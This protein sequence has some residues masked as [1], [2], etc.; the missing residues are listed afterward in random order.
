MP[1]KPCFDGVR[2][3]LF[4]YIWAFTGL[5]NVS[6]VTHIYIYICT[7][8]IYMFSTGT[9]QHLVVHEAELIKELKLHKSLD[10]GTPSY[11]S[12]AVEPMLG[13][14]II[15]ANGQHWS[16]QKKLIAPEFFLHKVKGIAGLMEE[17]TMAMISTWERRLGESSRL[18]G[19]AA[20]AEFMV[21]QDLRGLSADII[22]RY[23]FGSSFSQGKNIFAKLANLQEA[24]SHQSLVFGL[25]NF[26]CKSIIVYKLIDKTDPEKHYNADFFPRRAIERYGDSELHQDKRKIERFIVD[27]CKNIYFAGYETTAL[28]ASW[29]LMLL[30]LHP[31]WQQRVQA[32]IIET[33]SLDN[34]DKLNQLKT[35]SMV[36]QESLRLYAPPVMLVREAFEDIKLGDFQLPKGVHVWSF[37]PELHR[38][39]DNWGPDVGEFKPERFA[40]GISEA[41]KYPQAYVPFGYGTRMCIGQTFAMLELK[42]VLSLLLSRF[43]FSMSPNYRHSP[44]YKMFVMP[45]YGMRLI[46]KGV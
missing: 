43:S 18:G 25:P 41:C 30:A 28:S 8:K 40:G 6:I 2:V 4:A 3:Y 15:K 29:T 22:S 33:G 14:G 21:D 10:L 17:C 12:K 11:L 44:V 46:V 27:S 35:L 45:Q 13:N 37:I 7:G 26:R 24:L 5:E 32:E 20:A 42:I 36:I 31:Q 39:P 9:H 34:L 38:D 16:F 23:C 19:A 1:T